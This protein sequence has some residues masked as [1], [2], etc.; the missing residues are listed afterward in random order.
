VTSTGSSSDGIDLQSTL[1]LDGAN[2]LAAAS[3]L[4]LSGGTLE[5][6]NAAAANGQTFSSLMLLASSSINL[7]G[8]TLTF[9]N[10]GGATGGATLTLFD[11]ITSPATDF[12]VRFLGNVTNDANFLA[13]MLGLTVNGAAARY[14]FDGT[15]TEVSAVPLP[16]AAWLLISGLGVMGATVRR[17]RAVQVLAQP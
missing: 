5:I 11:Y 7:H 9:N 10:L 14:S 12:A 13:L 4:Q 8:S 3:A 2:R 1:V 15:Y 16:A 17:R 6:A